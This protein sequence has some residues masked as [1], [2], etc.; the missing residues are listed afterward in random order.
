MPSNCSWTFS[1]NTP[2]GVLVEFD[3]EV[4]CN[5]SSCDPSQVQYTT[6][7]DPPNPFAGSG[8]LEDVDCN[9]YLP[10][11]WPSNLLRDLA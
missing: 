8:S 3:P 9:A 4:K 11:S 2:T 10:V 7:L 1:P 6:A 5:P